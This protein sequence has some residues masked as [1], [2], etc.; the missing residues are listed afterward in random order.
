VA[1]PTTETSLDRAAFLTQAGWIPDELI[2]PWM[3]PMIV[4]IWDRL[5]PYVE[6]ERQRRHEPDY[7][8]QVSALAERRGAWRA[9]HVPNAE[10]TWMEHAL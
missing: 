5:K 10:I 1:A 9:A 2:M 8:R 7:Y 3:N 4:K 6:Y